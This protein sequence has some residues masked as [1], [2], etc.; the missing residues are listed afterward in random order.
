[1]INDTISAL[2][3]TL[4]SLQKN[5]LIE[6]VDECSKLGATTNQLAPLFAV[7]YWVKP[8]KLTKEEI[9]HGKKLAKKYKNK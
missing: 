6:V 2:Q 1:M 7:L 9:K 3:N 8:K 4:T 5:Q